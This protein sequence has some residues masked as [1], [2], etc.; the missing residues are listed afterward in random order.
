MSE[1][2]DESQSQKMAGYAGPETL[3]TVCAR[4]ALLSE[5]PAE[6][7]RESPGS[8]QGAEHERA[9]TLLHASLRPEPGLL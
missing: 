1:E 6:G 8:D 4:L 3:R 5:R 7:D 9:Q 2:K